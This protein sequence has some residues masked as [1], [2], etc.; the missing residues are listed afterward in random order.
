[1][2]KMKVP[3]RFS[4]DWFEL[5]RDWEAKNYQM[6]TEYYWLQQYREAQQK[7]DEFDGKVRH[8]IYHGLLNQRHTDNS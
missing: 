7:L 6:A 5:M 3:E 8:R 1:M 2:N 4:D